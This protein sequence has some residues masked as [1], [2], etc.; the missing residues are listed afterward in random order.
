M[1]GRYTHKYTWKQLHK[2][3]QLTTPP[4]EFAERYNVSPTQD[5][6]VVRR[7]G[8]EGRSEKGRRLDMLRWGLIP[9]WAKDE[10]FGNKAINARAETV[11]TSGA[12]RDSW[13][14]RRCLVP[15]SG[16]YEWKKLDAGG[17]R[18]QPHYITSSDGEPFMLAGLWTSWK[19]ADARA[20]E[21]FSII[22]TTPNALMAKVHDRMPVI[23]GPADWDAWLD[24]DSGDGGVGGEVE[25]LL[26]P[27]PAELMVAFPVSSKV[28][29]PRNDGPEL[30]QP[31]K[32]QELP[33]IDEP[34]LFS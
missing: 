13:R 25:S 21:T 2:L 1:C 28:N 18:K 12:F 34:G 29:S 11:A 10:T 24:S 32:S 22:T 16:F 20:I 19:G 30:I 23:L 31:V 8:A 26:R 4:I 27:Y 3:L 9:S 7:G 15:V 33:P 14:R 6:P 5:A 17:K